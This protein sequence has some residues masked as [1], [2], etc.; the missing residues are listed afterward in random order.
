MG[1]ESCCMTD[2]SQTAPARRDPESIMERQK[3]KEGQFGVYGV[4]VECLPNTMFRVD[5]QGGEISELIG[6]QLLFTLVGKMR[7]NRI[8]VLPGDRIIGYVTK[9]DLTQGKITFRTK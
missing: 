8:R 6:K 2:Q 3:L 7:L 9:Y 4:V 1:G 5:I